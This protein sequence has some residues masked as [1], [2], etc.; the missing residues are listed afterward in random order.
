[1]SK[2]SIQCWEFFRCAQCR[3][4]VFQSHEPACWLVSGTFCRDEI[5]GKFVE[6]MTLCFSCEVFKRNMNPIHMAATCELMRTQFEEFNLAIE[7]RDR[8]M[9]DTSLELAVG[10]SEIFEALKAI[11]TGDPSV[12]I[13]E[14]SSLELI[15]KVKR[16][17]N[18]AAENLGE[19][20]DLSHEFAIGLAEHFDVLHRV[21]SGDLSARVKGSSEVEL[22]E[23]LKTV[24]NLMIDSVAREIADRRQTEAAVRESEEKYRILINNIQDGVFIHQDGVLKF[25]NDT[26]V[27]M[28]GYTPEE[29]IGGSIKA[30]IAPEDWTM[31]RENY[32]RR[33]SEK[34]FAREYE[35]RMLHKDGVTR[36]LTKVSVAFFVYR[37]EPAFIGTVK[38]ITRQKRDEI[39]KKKLESRLQRSQKMEAIGTLAGGVAHDLNNILS[40]IVSYPELIL[41]DLPSDSPLRKPIT[42]IQ[43]AG[44]R[45]AAIVQDLLTLARRAVS[46]MEVVNFNEIIRDFLISPEFHRIRSFHPTIQIETDLASDLLNING[47]PVHLSKTVMNL[48]SNAAEAM[49]D[50][51]MIRLSTANRYIDRPVKGYDAVKEGD[52]IAVTVADSGVGISRDDLER[53]FEP[54]YTKKVM[55][56][57]G[58]GLGMAVVWGTIKDHD[59]Y[60]DVISTEKCGATFT[61]YFPVTRSIRRE[62]VGALSLEDYRGNG[63]SILVVDDVAE[64]REIASAILMKLGYEVNSVASGEAAVE[65]LRLHKVAL[66]VLDMIMEPGMDGLETYRRILGICPGQKAIVASGFSLSERV[67]EI[68]QLGAGVYVKKPYAFEKIA[69]AVRSELE[70]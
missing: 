10:L 51:G 68:Q 19:I 48:V 3:C 21:S 5:Q 35:C 46:N 66:V 26:M 56:R 17:V 32:Q 28:V 14:A 24:T 47:S 27:R 61:L 55:G 64:Q 36:V 29:L 22:L 50:G 16:Q 53:I 52:Y 62:R 31:V 13:S 40:G 41:M 59:G 70:K 7:K 49:P 15:K 39:E 12:R 23:K 30:V 11:A 44:E 54:F 60:I 2:S 69:M 58:T 45:A 4:P 38:D 18:D 8:E 34:D 65:Y 57:S 42:T 33:L 63:E 43:L 1:M 37:N 25:A 9:E 20:V 67:R 6:K